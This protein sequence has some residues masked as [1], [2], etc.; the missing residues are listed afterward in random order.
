[1]R[2]LARMM[3]VIGVT[4]VGCAQSTNVAAERDA[5]MALDREW[6]QTTKDVEKF[7]SYYAPDAAVYPPNMP[8][9]TGSGKVKETFSQFDN[10]RNGFPT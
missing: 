3:F 4:G 1:M 5:L 6:S 10:A 9:V 7:V 2:Y 8:L